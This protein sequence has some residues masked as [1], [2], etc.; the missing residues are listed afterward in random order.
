MFSTKGEDG[1]I[2]MDEKLREIREKVR[3][4][5]RSWWEKVDENLQ[6]W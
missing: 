3:G 6:Y 4:I 5:V 2:N 1:E